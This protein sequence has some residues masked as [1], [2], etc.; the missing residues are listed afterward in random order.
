MTCENIALNKA[1]PGDLV[2][3]AYADRNRDKRQKPKAPDA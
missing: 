2:K 1:E 3:A